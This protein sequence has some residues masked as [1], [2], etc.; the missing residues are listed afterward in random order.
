MSKSDKMFEELGYEKYNE[1]VYIN[2]HTNL[3]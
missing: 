2:Y 3:D 1:Y